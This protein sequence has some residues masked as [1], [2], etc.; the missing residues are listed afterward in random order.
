VKFLVHA[1]LVVS[2]ASVA[3]CALG[4]DGVHPRGD[5]SAGRMDAAVAACE[6]PCDTGEVCQEGACVPAGVDS[7]GDTVPVELDCD[8]DDP[9]IGTVAEQLCTSA[10]AEGL[11]RCT[12][13][14]WDA[15]D[16]PTDCECNTGDPPRTIACAQ[17]G[18]Q[19][20]SCVGGAW[21]NDGVCMNQGACT[22]G[23]V[24]DLGA[25]TNCGRSQR[26]CQADCTWGAPECLDAGACAAGEVE[27]QS[28]GCGNCGTGTQTQTRTCDAACNWGAWSGW[29]TC[30]GGGMC[31][32][33]AM[34]QQTQ[35]CGNCNT[36]TQTRTRTCTAACAWSYGNWSTCTGGGTC[37]PGATR[38]CDR[39]SSGTLTNCGVETCTSACRWPGTCALAPGAACLS[40]M[41]SNYQCCVTSGGQGGWQFC[42]ATTCQWFSCAVN[43]CS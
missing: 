12:D 32:P 15:C 37:A 7:D 20:Q 5:G 27:M 1:V 3:G 35:N 40:E 24:E 29:S 17:C 11:T 13:G 19:T 41:G 42:S 10:C 30:S 28:Q 22:P 6:P 31:A 16:A 25:C 33:G 18:M 34:E 38:G 43:S 36:G 39:N 8:D 2:L 9:T 4:N 14:V 26:T 21:T 23:D